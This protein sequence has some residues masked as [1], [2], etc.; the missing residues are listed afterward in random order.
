[1]NQFKVG[2]FYTEGTIYEEVFKSHLKSS[3]DKYNIP[4]IIKAIPN[5]NSWHKNVAKKP[6]IILD[7]LN[8]MEEN[9]TL[10]F[11]DVDATI[12]K[13]PDLFA[14][15]PLDYDIGFHR[16]DWNS[17]YGYKDSNKKELLTGTMFFRVRPS[18]KQLVKEW[19]LLATQTNEW[20]QKVLEKIVDKF[21]LKVYNLPI[22]YCY[23]KSLPSGAEPLVKCEAVVVH[24]QLSR[25][26][27]RILK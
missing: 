14:N 15:L 17:W 13:E 5:Q 7:I 11:L 27:K 19:S 12:E 26:T 16:L 23:I 20:E 8:S 18:V 6:G 1:M 4:S 22:E 24:H 3:L 21:N 2:C 9:E 25:I 10:V